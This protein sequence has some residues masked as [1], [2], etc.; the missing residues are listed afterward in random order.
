MVLNPFIEL[1]RQTVVALAI[2]GYILLLCG[3]IY[4]SVYWGIRKLAVLTVRYRKNRHGDDWWSGPMG[5]GL[6][7][8]PDWSIAFMS[9][10][11]V[12]GVMLLAL[13][14]LVWVIS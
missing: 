1:F 4:G 6:L 3:I 5:I 2:G 14:G 12:W 13:S 7:P 10:L 11:L 8:P 9:I